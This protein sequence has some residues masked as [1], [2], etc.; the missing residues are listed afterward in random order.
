MDLPGKTQEDIDLSVKENVLTIASANETEETKE[1]VQFLL[2]ER[3]FSSDFKRTFTLASDCDATK[4][5][6]V[7]K[8]GVLEVTIPFKAQAAAQKIHIQAA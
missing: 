8:N 6:A 1:E 2:R 4:I 5:S 3:T 7:F